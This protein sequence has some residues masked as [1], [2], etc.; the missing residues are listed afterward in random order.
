MDD[1]ALDDH[2]LAARLPDWDRAGEGGTAQQGEA[3]AQHAATAGTDDPVRQGGDGDNRRGAS[4]GRDQ[5]GEV[6]SQG[7]Q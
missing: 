7:G 3:V 1:D 2:G 4:H 5:R 6:R